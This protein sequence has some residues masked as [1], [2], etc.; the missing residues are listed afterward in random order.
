MLIVY[1][2]NILV[3]IHPVH[4]YVNTWYLIFRKSITT[5]YQAIEFSPSTMLNRDAICAIEPIVRSTALGYKF[6]L[7]P[8][9]N[10]P[11]TKEK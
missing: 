1:F 8:G 9:R 3:G 5:E 7:S 6:A 2:T 11:Y 10:N 4:Y